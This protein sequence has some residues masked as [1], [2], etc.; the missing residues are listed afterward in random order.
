[1]VGQYGFI[2]IFLLVA[3]LFGVAPIGVAWILS[4]K[5]SNPRKRET[6]ESGIE[7]FGPTWVRFKP[8]YYLFALAFL[9][10]DVEAVMLLPWAVAYN[11]LPLYAVIE[12]VLFILILGLGLVYVW[13]KDWLTWM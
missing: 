8:Q 9:I 5:K 1:M 7:T 6:Y 3:L 10:F 13:L 2:G 4:P 12:A 11:H